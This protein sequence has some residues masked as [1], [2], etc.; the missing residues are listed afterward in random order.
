MEGCDQ[1]ILKE[2]KI[3]E[4]FAVVEIVEEYQ[5][6]LARQVAKIMAQASGFE[7]VSCHYVATCVSELAN[8]LFFHTIQG[9]KV[10]ISTIKGSGGVGIEVVAE[11]SGP[12]IPDL[13][14]AMQD[15]FTTNGGLGGG[16]PGVERLM[17]EF[18]ITS[19]V[20][21]GTRIIARKWQLCR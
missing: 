17:D 7:R 2:E 20:G 8:N 19:A 18:E 21:V 12:G 6:A 5:V 15:G 16:L 14:L 1:L 11:D 13:E 9:G 4:R 10:T 3:S